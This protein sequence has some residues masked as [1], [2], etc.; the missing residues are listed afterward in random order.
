M[1]K[2]QI[3]IILKFKK[4]NKS[5]KFDINDFNIRSDGRI[6]YIC[7]HGVGHTIYSPNNNFV[8]GCDGCC[9]GLKIIKSGRNK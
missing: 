2:K 8:H 6:E 9:R 5:L 4:L 1:T 3:E 7:S